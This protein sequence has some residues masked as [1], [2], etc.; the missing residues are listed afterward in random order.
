[1]Q[2]E[3]QMEENARTFL[4]GFGLELEEIVDL[5]RPVG[6]NELLLLAGSVVEGLANAESDLDLIL[7][8]DGPRL[9]SLTL[10]EERVETS[11]I[12]HPS[13]LEV[14]IDTYEPKELERV[15]ATMRVLVHCLDD[16]ES[17]DT[18]PIIYD[19]SDRK[20]LH[21]LAT[22]IPLANEAAVVR[23]RAGAFVDRLPEV[24]AITRMIDHFSHR[25]DAISHANLQQWDAASFSLMRSATDI[26]GALN[27]AAGLTNHNARWS[28]P[29][30]RQ[31]AA[32]LPP[33]DVDFAVDLML[34][35]VQ[36][37]TTFDAQVD[38]MNELVGV[39]AQQLPGLLPISAKI[40]EHFPITLAR[41]D[42]AEATMPKPWE[43]T[44]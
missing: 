21:R 24:V 23:A 9:A 10:R 16:P 6:E 28:I 40:A 7:I 26:V 37:N 1:M 36:D 34:S 44:T 25:E 17:I 8:G 4:H 27:A 22:S 18:F 39:V 29:L 15:S 14:S 43:A 32:Q 2:F 35:R 30:L 38:R 19:E 41:V 31:A 42:G 33:F 3:Q 12:I 13:G 11:T 5:I 20:L